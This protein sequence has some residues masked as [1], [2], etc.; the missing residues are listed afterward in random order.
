EQ[1]ILP[2]ILGGVIEENTDYDVKY[3]EGLGEVAILTPALDK[4]E[5]D[6][7]V[8]YTGTGLKD[9]LEEETEPGESPDSVYDRVKKGYD[10]EFDVKWLEPLGFENAYTLTYAPDSGYEAETIS[11]L[12]EISQKNDMVF[13][14]PHPFYERVGEGDRKSTR[15]NSSHVSI[16]LSLHDALPI[17]VYDRVKKGYDEEFD[18]KWLE[19][20][21]FENAYTLTYAPD[22]GYEAETI[23]ELAEISQKND[24]VFGAPHP[25]YER[26]G[27]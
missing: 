22:S 14:A 8:E 5:I 12:A 21:G 10:E 4:G 17:C 16:C 15:L 23:S 25:F 9:V 6:L 27:E 24:M 1:Y 19:P 26:V 2:Y 18:V 13:G 7:Y 20:L 3:E 11:E